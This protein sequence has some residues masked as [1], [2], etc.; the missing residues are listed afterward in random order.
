MKNI[1]F[2]EQINQFLKNKAK[3]NPRYVYTRISLRTQLFACVC[4]PNVVHI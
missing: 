1:T 4:R 2:N 3:G